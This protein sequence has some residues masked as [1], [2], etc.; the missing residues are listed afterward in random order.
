[1]AKNVQRGPAIP[2]LPW[3]R[4][5]LDEALDVNFTIDLKALS[6][7]KIRICAFNQSAFK[8]STAGALYLG[9]NCEVKTNI[10]NII[11][12]PV[13]TYRLEVIHFSSTELE[14][15]KSVHGTTAKR[16]LGLS[17]RFHYHCVLHAC[18]ITPIDLL[19]VVKKD[20]NVL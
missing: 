20:K 13:L 3:A 2:H 12:C 9:L 4:Y 1:M 15:Q 11:N 19:V 17:K 5:R 18:Y 14:E 8:F 16:G 6:H 7:I 10:W